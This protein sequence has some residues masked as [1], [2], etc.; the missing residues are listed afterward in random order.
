MES[1]TEESSA[2]DTAAAPN[3][4]I[5]DMA[6]A[7]MAVQA[8]ASVARAVISSAESAKAPRALVEAH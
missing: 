3:G 4:T 8:A 5:T 7:N 2:T 6:A 1:N